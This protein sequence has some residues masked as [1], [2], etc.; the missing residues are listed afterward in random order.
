MIMIEEM[1]VLLGMADLG[2]EGDGGGVAL[3]R[4]LSWVI[5]IERQG[6]RGDRDA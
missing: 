2:L 1:S 6:A 3:M 4:K 5:D